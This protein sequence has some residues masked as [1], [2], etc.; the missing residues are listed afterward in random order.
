[1]DKKL[2]RNI[3]LAITFAVFLVAV[4]I[5]IDK[6]TGVA[7]FIWGILKPV[8]IGFC[9][10]FVLNRPYITFTGLFEKLFKKAKKPHPKAI[11]VLAIL[12]V[13]IIFLAVITLL[14][15]LI[16]P[17]TV[18]SV[19]NLYNNRETYIANITEFTQSV[20]KMLG[21][22]ISLI[23]E[24]EKFII[25][26]IEKLPD[27]FMNAIPVIFAA[28]G[29]VAATVMNVIMGFA[30][31][32]Y[33]LASK[34]MLLSQCRRSLY[35]FV[36]TKIALKISEITRIMSE[37]FGDYLGQ[38]L[39]DALI[40][41]VLCFICMSVIGLP[42]AILISTIVA[43][44][45]VIP[46]FGPFIGAIPSAFILLIGKPIN[47]LWFI[48]MIIVLQQLNEHL[49]SPRLTVRSTGMPVWLTFV[50]LFVGYGIGNFF[51]MLLG[52]PTFGVIYRIINDMILKKSEKKAEE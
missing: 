11:K 43:L 14:F 31:S 38:R 23:G 26:T 41:G 49:I 22:D 52:V 15:G 36:P 13:Y 35:A 7:S 27:Y 18:E 1:M 39:L 17:Q 28:A 8:I 42:Y 25:D 47:A 24:T 51:G 19:V 44:T 20:E 2:L 21:L 10:A 50:A 30:M 37:V 12:T 45:N 3:L 29:D 46:V 34:E 16:V 33:M 32:V 5:N 48:I 9:I 6:I 4:I 40:V